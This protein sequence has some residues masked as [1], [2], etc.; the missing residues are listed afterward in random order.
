VTAPAVPSPVRTLVAMPQPVLHSE[1]LHFTPL[2][3]RDADALHVIWGDPE[4]IWWGSHHTLDETRSFVHQE[5]GEVV[6]DALLQPVPRPAGEIE[7]GW[8]LARAHWGRGYATEAGVRLVSH[9][10]DILG[11]D[12]LIADI[13]PH[14]ERSGAVARRLGMTLRP[15]SVERAGIVHQV[16]ELQQ[17]G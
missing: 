9:A 11:V 17:Q 12:V 2:S 3:P 7:V 13:A 16:W 5:T 6:G 4:V 10:F 1:R 15:G 14:N 8:H